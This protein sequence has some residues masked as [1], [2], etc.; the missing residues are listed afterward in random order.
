[1]SS[2]KKG[3]RSLSFTRQRKVLRGFATTTSL[4]T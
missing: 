2:I 4:G 1:L 3:Y